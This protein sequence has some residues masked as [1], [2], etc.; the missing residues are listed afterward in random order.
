MTS[1]RHADSLATTL[2]IGFCY[3]AKETFFFT[4][5]INDP[6]NSDPLEAGFLNAQ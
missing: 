2:Q 6:Y 4:F 1:F 3:S 5:P